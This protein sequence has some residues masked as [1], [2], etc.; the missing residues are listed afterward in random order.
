[1]SESLTASERNPE[2]AGVPNLSDLSRRDQV[3][4]YLKQNLGQWVDGV[5]MSNERVGGSEGLKRLRELREA[6][7]LIQKRQKPG[8]DQYQYRLVEQ[9]GLVQPSY[10]PEYKEEI[11]NGGIPVNPAPA[12]SSRP[13]RDAEGPSPDWSLTNPAASVYETSFKLHGEKVVAQI[14]LG[15][16]RVTWYWGVR[17]PARD[18]LKHKRVVRPRHERLYGGSTQTKAEAQDAVYAQIHELNVNGFQEDEA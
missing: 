4:T 10:R 17:V 18:P 11:P 9:D 16:D 5:E 12:R 1:M 14:R 13:K 7:Y 2:E 3:L 8:A 6:G 15:M